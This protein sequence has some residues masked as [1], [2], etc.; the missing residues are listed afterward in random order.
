VYLRGTIVCR[1]SL[2]SVPIHIDVM[3]VVHC[4]DNF[5]YEPYFQ[6]SNVASGSSLVDC[7]FLQ[8]TDPS[9]VG[10]I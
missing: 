1:G 7:M 9:V 3:I 10:F 4:L 6:P 2:T 5:S 8:L